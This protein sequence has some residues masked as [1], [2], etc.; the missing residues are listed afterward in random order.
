MITKLV[1][2]L[3]SAPEKSYCEQALLSIYTARHHNQDAYI[4]L[5]TDNVTDKLFSGKRAEILEYISEKIVVELPE[6]MSMMERSR[7]LKTSVRNL[8]NGDLMFVDCDTLTTRSLREIDDC[9]FE[10]GAVPDSHLPV[11]KFNPALYEKVKKLGSQLDWDISKEDYY[12]SSGVIYA[13]DTEK[14]KEFFNK[15]HSYW[16]EG[17]KTGVSI[18]QPSFAKSNIEC[19]HIIKGIDNGWN[20]VMYTHPLFDRDARILHFCSFRNMTYAFGESFL[21]KVRKEGVKGNEFIKYSILHPY[22]TY[23]PFDNKIHNYSFGEYLKLIFTI[24]RTAKLIS[25]NLNADYE[26]YIDSRKIERYVKQL[27]AKKLFTTGAL[28]FVAYKAYKVRFS[29]KYKYLE[30]T[31]SI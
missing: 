29:K 15:W 1:Y 17:T 4:V 16:F 10:L 26:D 12:F 7:W 27:F 30:N 6:E 9:P 22:E 11:A 2:V 8:I 19:G 18:D 23:I 13:K 31:C 25:K 3:T 5:V 24:R 20:C 21:N 14:N 28:L